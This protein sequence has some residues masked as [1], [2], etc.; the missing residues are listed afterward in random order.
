MDFFRLKMLTNAL[1]LQLMKK[2]LKK[3][4]YFTALIHVGVVV[5]EPF[6][7]LAK[8]PDASVLVLQKSVASTANVSDVK[9][10]MVFAK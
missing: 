6:Q 3:W 8:E 1:P 4:K 9:T 5:A 7:I 10:K 2:K